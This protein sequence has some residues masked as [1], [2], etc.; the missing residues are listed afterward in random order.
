MKMA[1]TFVRRIGK[2]EGQRPIVVEFSNINEK[3][4]VFSFY[5]ELKKKGI[6][7]TNDCTQ[8]ERK[9][10]SAFKEIQMTIRREFNCISKIKN[11]KKGNKLIFKQKEYRIEEA[12][13]LLEKM[14]QETSEK[15]TPEKNWRKKGQKKRMMIS[16]PDAEV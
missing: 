4:E 14:R 6:T 16:P 11:D 7:I 1:I 10:Y 3:R 13:D 2:T 12:H 8:E 15:L 5:K 9:E